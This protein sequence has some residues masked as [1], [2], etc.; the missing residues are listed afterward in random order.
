MS[1]GVYFKPNFTHLAPGGPSSSI[2]ELSK[3]GGKYVVDSKRIMMKRH[4]YSLS[5]AR[6]SMSH[7]VIVNIFTLHHLGRSFS[8]V[9]IQSFCPRYFSCQGSSKSYTD[10]RHPYYCQ[11]NCLTSSFFTYLDMVLALHLII[12]ARRLQSRGKSLPRHSRGFYL[13]IRI[14][15]RE[16]EQGLWLF[17]CGWDIKIL[18]I[19]WSATIDR[20]TH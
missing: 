18:R 3:S 11:E 5:C 6:A 9:N 15:K 13:I 12:L 16:P 8:L 10:R 1:F 20:D 2:L 19:Y 7:Q 17:C 14:I 4:I